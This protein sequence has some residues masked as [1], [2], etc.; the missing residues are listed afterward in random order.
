MPLGL[1]VP[2]ACTPGALAGSKAAGGL[3]LLVQRRPPYTQKGC[4]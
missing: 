4:V 1:E 2:A 3:H